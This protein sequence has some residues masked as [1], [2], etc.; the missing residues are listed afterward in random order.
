VG[1]Q[2]LDLLSLA[3]RRG[4]GIGGGDIAGHVARA[5][6]DRAQ[7]LAGRCVRTAARLESARIAVEL[8]G[9]IA[10]EALLVDALPG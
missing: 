2:H 5:F 3:T 6:V 4:V 1:E 9:A 10:H 7:D 8:A